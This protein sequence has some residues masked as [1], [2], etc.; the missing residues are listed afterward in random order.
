MM[1]MK[2]PSG[3]QNLDKLDDS[4]DMFGF[5]EVDVM[6]AKKSVKVQ[7]ANELQAMQDNDIID[8]D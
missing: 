1:S 3:K 4:N 2:V 7:R 8:L 6:K 5:E